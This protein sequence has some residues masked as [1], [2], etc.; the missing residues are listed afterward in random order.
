MTKPWPKDNKTV[1]FDEI[2]K[3]LRDAVDQLYVLKRVN[4]GMDVH[5]DGLDIGEAEKVCS[6][7]PDEKLSDAQLTYD[8][9][10]QGRDPMEVLLGLAVQLG[11]EQ[12]R[13]TVYS[14][15]MA[16]IAQEMAKLNSRTE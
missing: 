15:P 12:G 8:D 3:P 1:S 14:D 6:F 2:V 5:W 11:I 16:K 10:E 13:R 9:E 7:S 4:K